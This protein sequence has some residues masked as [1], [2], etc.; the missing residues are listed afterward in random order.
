MCN[1]ERV[2]NDKSVKRTEKVQP[3][4]CATWKKE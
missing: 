2:Q 3:E 1:M 4:K